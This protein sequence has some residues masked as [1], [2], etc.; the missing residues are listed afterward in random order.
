MFKLKENQLL[1]DLQEYILETGVELGFDKLSA[2]QRCLMLG[3]EV[4]ELFKS[5]RKYEKI[6]IDKDSKVDSIE[7]EL[8][9]ILKQ[10]CA[11][12]NYFQIDLEK[13]FIEKEKKNIGRWK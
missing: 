5:V 2:T 10:V 7:D 3:E 4:G 1:K 13:A 11:V 12:A 9:D 8:A 6:K